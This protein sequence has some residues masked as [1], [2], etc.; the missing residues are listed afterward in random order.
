ML[1]DYFDVIE[2]WLSHRLDTIVGT[3]A[4]MCS[5]GIYGRTTYLVG[6][7]YKTNILSGFRGGSPFGRRKPILI[8]KL[9]TS[10]TG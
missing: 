5:E 3:V 6:A 1:V 8:W 2:F 4:V 9:E 10:V 7:L